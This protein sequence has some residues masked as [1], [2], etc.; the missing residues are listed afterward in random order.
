[1]TTQ[2]PLAIAPSQGADSYEELVKI[3]PSDLNS[4]GLAN[5]PNQLAKWTT[6]TSGSRQSEPSQQISPDA[7]SYATG[8]RRPE[9]SQQI[10]SP[11]ATKYAAASRRNESPPQTS[12]GS[13][14]ANNRRDYVAWSK[15]ET[16]AL[17]RW[18][19]ANDNFNTMKRN[20]ARML[21]L[22]AEHL[23]TEM[24]GCTKT[25][26]QCDHKIRN[27]KKCYK[28]LKEKLST[29]G[30]AAGF[31]NEKES[32]KEYILDQFPYFEEFERLMADEHIVKPV[33]RSHMKIAAL[34]ASQKSP[35]PS[36]RSPSKGEIQNPKHGSAPASL[37]HGENGN[38][39]RDGSGSASPPHTVDD[40]PQH[41]RSSI[42]SCSPASEE[43]LPD[44]T[45]FRFIRPKGEQC[46]V[47]HDEATSL[48]S[49]ESFASPNDLHL[50]G[51]AGSVPTYVHSDQLNSRQ[52]PQHAHPEMP[53]DEQPDLKRQRLTAASAHAN[54]FNPYAQLMNMGSPNNMFGLT[55]SDAM[56]KCPM[57]VDLTDMAP[58]CPIGMTG[59]AGATL[60]GTNGGSFGSVAL[61]PLAQ[62][63]G[64]PGSF[65]TTGNAESESA[66]ATVDQ[67]NPHG[68]LLNILKMMSRNPANE[69]GDPAHPD[70]HDSSKDESNPQETAQILAE[71]IKTSLA[72]KEAVNRQKLHLGHLQS[73][74]Q[75]HTMRAEIL[76][77]NGQVSRASKVMDKIDELE[78]E[79]HDLLSRPLNQF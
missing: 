13:T 34:G 64:K 4:N 22:L 33:S 76:Y 7:A 71:H 66:G 45:R 51:E 17:V 46:P 10:A 41:D 69:T 79:L 28:K 59:G 29:E 65:T 75:R 6:Y 25:P 47:G 40:K 30:T 38:E 67:N 56:T 14:P 68:T 12:A 74:I 3:E 1:M 54:M 61:P 60:F 37:M 23:R 49:P 62:M 9:P 35:A 50:K 18:L 27:L 52:C 44:M 55:G 72:K 77:N 42:K 31:E 70:E 43:G 20:T 36:H 63:T 78:L 5:G 73:Q 19:D 57:N 32:M 24:P 39:T 8:G 58:K 2:R 26:K 48:P 15:R 53:T 21:P 16:V 11:P